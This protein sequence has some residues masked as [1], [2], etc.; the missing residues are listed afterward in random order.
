[1]HVNVVKLYFFISLALNVI[2]TSFKSGM[3]DSIG[4]LNQMG[5]PIREGTLI[6]ICEISALPHHLSSPYH[7]ITIYMQ[8]ALDLMIILISKRLIYI[9]I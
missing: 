5:V 6:S 1:M 3:F 9:L 4:S 8:V 2:Y 7:N